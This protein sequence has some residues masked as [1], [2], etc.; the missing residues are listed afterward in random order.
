MYSVLVLVALIVGCAYSQT[1]APCTST[2]DCKQDL[3]PMYCRRAQSCQDGGGTCEV[4]PDMCPPVFAPVC[5]CRNVTYGN[6]CMAALAED[7]VSY[8]GPCANLRTCL[9]NTNCQPGEYCSKIMSNCDDTGMCTPLPDSCPGS[10]APVCGCDGTSYGSECLAN[11]KGVNVDTDGPCPEFVKCTTASD[12]PQFFNCKRP[13]GGCQAAFGR[14]VEPPEIC[15]N[16]YDPV[17][18]CDGTT[19]I[20][21]CFAEEAGI[22]I[23]FVGECNNTSECSS[24]S[25]CDNMLWCQKEVN[26]CTD[27][28]FVGL[29]VNRPQ[30]CYHLYSPVCGCDNHTYPNDCYAYARGINIASMGACGEEF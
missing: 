28:A 30:F 2:T 11:I 10:L 1:G 12:C 8:E 4:V 9:N 7:S 21:G 25:D 20:N 18:G 6:D 16:Q 13:V 29:C 3:L 5:G 19:Y 24:D 26:T 23:S 15:S 27:D 14:C 17:C 22:A